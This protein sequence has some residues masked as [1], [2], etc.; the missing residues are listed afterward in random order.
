[1]TD[2]GGKVEATTE[3]LVG[4]SRSQREGLAKDK[5]FDL[6]W[7][8]SLKGTGVSREE[9][10]QTEAT[11][12]QRRPRGAGGALRHECRRWQGAHEARK[13]GAPSL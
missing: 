6:S 13:L 12:Q 11:T 5:M 2:G 1:M 3:C 10:S 4:S 8:G 9:R 7:P